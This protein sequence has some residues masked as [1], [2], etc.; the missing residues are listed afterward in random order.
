MTRIRRPRASHAYKRTCNVSYYD[1]HEKMVVREMF[2]T[3]TLLANMPRSD[4][5]HLEGRTVCDNVQTGNVEI[6]R[7]ADWKRPMSMT[8]RQPHPMS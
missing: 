2:G 8:F 6:K 1:I 5:E 3:K 7:T 4:H